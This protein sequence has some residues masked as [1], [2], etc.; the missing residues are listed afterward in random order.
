M[1]LIRYEDAKSALISHLTTAGGNDGILTRKVLALHRKADGD[2]TDYVRTNCKLCID[3]IELFQAH[4]TQ[5]DVGKAKFLKPMTHFPRLKISGVSISVSIDLW[6][7]R[8]DSKGNKSTGGAMLVFSKSG[9]PDKNLQERCKA[10]TLLIHEFL[11]DSTKPSE[12]LDPNLCMA[13]DVFNGT[14]YRAK[15][16][17]KLLYK[18]VENSCGEVATVWPSVEPPSNYYGPPLPNC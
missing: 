10:I 6:V 7:E 11:R 17:Q 12:T 14:V 1:L 9:G 4:E 15:T 18:T 3:A 13:I 8:L 2:I 16:Q 5:M